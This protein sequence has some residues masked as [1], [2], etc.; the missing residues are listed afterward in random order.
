MSKNLA[1]LHIK[2]GQDVDEQEINC[3][4]EYPAEPH[5]NTE[6]L[7]VKVGNYMKKNLRKFRD[8]VEYYEACFYEILQDGPNDYPNLYNLIQEH[9]QLTVD[10]VMEA[11]ANEKVTGHEV[12][13]FLTFPHSDGQFYTCLGTLYRLEEQPTYQLE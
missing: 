9:E 13:Y 10:I 1:I 4:F 11:L 5:L 7:E 8:I 2:A 3:V 6:E 12:F